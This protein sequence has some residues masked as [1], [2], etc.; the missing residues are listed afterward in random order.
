MLAPIIYP[1]LSQSGMIAKRSF[2][3]WISLILKKNLGAP[4]KSLSTSWR[5]HNPI[6][7]YEPCILAH[8]FYNTITQSSGLFTFENEGCIKSPNLFQGMWS[9]TTTSY[10]H[11]L[12]NNKLHISHFNYINGLQTFFWFSGFSS[13]LLRDARK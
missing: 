7:S 3:F 8:T 10:L 1:F 2:S 9:S 13:R 5:L 11:S 12:W 6:L 4:F